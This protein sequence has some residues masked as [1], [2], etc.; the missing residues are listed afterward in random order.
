MTQE[1]NNLL[2]IKGA[3]SELPPED[4]KTFDLAR[5][6][7]DVIMKKYPIHAPLVICLVGAELAAQG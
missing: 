5:L 7:V 4:K 1:Q 3:I 6:E 2:V